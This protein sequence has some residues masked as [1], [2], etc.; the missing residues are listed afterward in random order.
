M[1]VAYDHQIFCRQAYGG[2]SRYF[3]R[4]AEHIPTQ[5]VDAKLFA[6]WHINRYLADQPKNS[7]HGRFVPTYPRGLKALAKAYNTLE[8]NRQLHSWAPDIVHE[9]FY[10][11]Q[12]SF[13]RHTRVTTVYDMISELFPE[14]FKNPEKMTHKK[15]KAL[16]RA[17]HII[18]I[19]EN[20]R[21]DLLNLFPIAED[22]V[23]VVYLGCDA[24]P[25]SGH[26]SFDVLPTDAPYI[27]YVGL[28]GGYKNFEA[29]LKAVAASPQL[30]K[31]FHILCFGGGYFTLEEQKKIA[32][33]GFHVGQVIQTSGSDQW[34]QHCL[35]HASTFVFP[36]LY[37]GFGIPPLEAMASDCPVVCSNVSSMPEVVGDA[38]E[39]FDPT[40][41]ED[42]TRAIERVVYNPE[43]AAKL[44][45]LG[46]QRL[47]QFT[48]DKCAQQTH[49]VYASL[50]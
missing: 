33:L 24:Q 50:I 34:L 44:V 11:W 6:P 8:V 16:D 23:S 20:T 27:M 17:D 12:P 48:W 3:A 14:S 35:R 19:S 31:D 30:K 26:Q 42:L 10:S 28:R 45:L 32:S 25:V 41:A 49:Q 7:I 40:S 22:K 38:A 18:C 9:T 36:S 5:N 15:L 47:C 2:I 4:L 46:R 39:F 21:L 43:V 37:E 13:H 1:K 29:L